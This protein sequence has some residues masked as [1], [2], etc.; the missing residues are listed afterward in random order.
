V[1]GAC[2]SQGTELEISF[3]KIDALCLTGGMDMTHEAWVMPHRSE[4][5]VAQFRKSVR[6][7]T[8]S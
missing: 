2:S 4:R 1:D 5:N 7:M 8:A 6:K 3:E